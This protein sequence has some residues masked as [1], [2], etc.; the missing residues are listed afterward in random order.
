M[1]WKKKSSPVKADVTT[2]VAAK[3]SGTVGRTRKGR[4]SITRVQSPIK[5]VDTNARQWNRYTP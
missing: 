1:V 4:D 2:R 3:V 5:V